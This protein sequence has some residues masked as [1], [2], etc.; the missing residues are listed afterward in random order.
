MRQSATCCALAALL[1]SACG[2]RAELP[3]ACVQASAGDVVAALRD[4]PGPVALSD[5]T[6]LSECVGEAVSDGDLQA[7]G[8][9]FTAAAAQL[10][11]RLPDR[12]AALQL[13]FLMGATERGAQ[14]TAGVQA[15]LAQRIAQTAGFD[16]GA[17]GQRA[18]LAR[19][20]SAGRRDG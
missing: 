17:R 12:D 18:T 2:G 13:G 11:R 5:G 19:G 8:L 7:V 6:L 1:L 20:R 10:A 9:T 4:A 3:A 15:E 16:G 14:R